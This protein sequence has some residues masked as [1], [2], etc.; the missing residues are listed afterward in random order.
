M[1]I[2]LP[3]SSASGTYGCVD[4][5]MEDEEV[6]T[7]AT[8]INAATYISIRSSLPSFQWETLS[9]VRARDTS[10]LREGDLFAV[11]IKLWR[12]ICNVTS[13]QK[14]PVLTRFASA[15]I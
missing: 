14:I 6:S 7:T 3:M 11:C 13:I 2:D 1:D 10:S 8:L 15:C 5:A 9:A 4:T 12:N